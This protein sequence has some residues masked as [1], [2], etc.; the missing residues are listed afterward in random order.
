MPRAMLEE[1]E[2]MVLWE[3]NGAASTFELEEVVDFLW[4]GLPDDGGV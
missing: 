2:V 1:S 3:E 4:E